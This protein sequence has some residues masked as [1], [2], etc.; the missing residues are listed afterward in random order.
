MECCGFWNVFA[1]F[2]PESPDDG[3]HSSGTPRISNIRGNGQSTVKSGSLPPPKKSHTLLPYEFYSIYAQEKEILLSKDN[4]L[5][6]L[7]HLAG[8]QK[9]VNEYMVKLKSLPW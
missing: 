7:P 6:L 9:I 8:K 1:L 2:R 4:V 3:V 5:F